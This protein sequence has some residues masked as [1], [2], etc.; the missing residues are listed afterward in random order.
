MNYGLLG[1][2]CLL[3]LVAS[4]A[5]GWVPLFIQL[6]HNRMQLALSSVAGFILGIALLHMLPHAIEAVPVA[7]ACLWVLIG[8]LVMF[9]LERF[10][11]FHHHEAP[12]EHT[13]AHDQQHP[14]THEPAHDEHTDIPHEH[15]MTWGGA[16]VGLTVHS[17]VDGIALA[18]AIMVEHAANDGEVHHLGLPGFAVFLVI[19]LHRPFDALT[20]GTLLAHSGRSRSLRHVINALFALVVPLGAVLFILGIGASHIDQATLVGCAL[21]FSAG[22]FL[23]IS[24]SDLLPEL[25]FHHHDRVKLSAALLLGLALAW[26]VA[27]FEARSH[28]HEHHHDVNAQ[29]EPADNHD[30]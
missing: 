13:H 6:T 9:F 16:L 23:C 2:Y 12:D 5:G 1:L 15:A 14:H 8:L 29:I 20:L 24:L 25:Q 18:A 28:A 21:G 19:F 17:L 26:A 3:I 22:V 27:F 30:H 10:F 11:C 4:L 7:T